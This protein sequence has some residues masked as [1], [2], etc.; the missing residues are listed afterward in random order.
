MKIYERY[1]DGELIDFKEEL[2]EEE[3]KI[4]VI[5][6]LM[7]YFF[8]IGGF[9]ILVSELGNADNVN[10]DLKNA[11]GTLTIAVNNIT[12]TYSCISD[13]TNTIQIP[14][15]CSNVEP[16][17]LIS[18]NETFVRSVVSTQLDIEFDDQQ[19]YFQQTVLPRQESIEGNRSLYSYC[20]VDRD[21]WKNEFEFINQSERYIWETNYNTCQQTQSYLFLFIGGLVVV[22]LLLVLIKKGYLDAGIERIRRK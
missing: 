6:K 11:N 22:M 8:I 2:N 18:C 12:N 9:L 20:A 3:Y 5:A 21:R 14:I 15:S 10:V 4:R 13:F 1:K 19:S 7:V 16:E 17:E